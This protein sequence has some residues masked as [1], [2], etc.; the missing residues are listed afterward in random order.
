MD[1]KRPACR[2]FV[3]LARQAPL[4]VIFRRGPSK[5]VQLIK[6]N[7]AN[8]SFESGQWFK[9]RIYE[10]RCDVT[11][12]GNLLVYFAAKHKGP[13]IREHSWTAVS[14]PPHL[15]ALMLWFRGDCWSGGGLFESDSAL[16]LNEAPSIKPDTRIAGGG[17]RVGQLNLGRGEDDPIDITRRLRDRWELL[18][19]IK[20]SY[21]T[22]FTTLQPRLMRKS[23]LQAILMSSETIT[24]F[25]G[26]VDYSISHTN[27][28]V[29][30]LDGAEWADWDR[31]GRLVFAKEGR[32]FAG[33][34]RSGGE[35][36]IRELAD[37]NENDFEEV[38][39]P[40]WALQW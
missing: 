20:T 36:K 3:L 2:L 33:E 8:D 27:G 15:S 39:A 13:D 19:E 21:Q 14:K 30:P 26:R 34:M 37:F 40:E 25:E 22:S 38:I 18:Q 28:A 4:G 17:L 1:E 23:L 16:S 32:L 29:I 5:Q 9:G 24:G 31:N 35:L 6:W 10:R 12:N 7:T 11:P